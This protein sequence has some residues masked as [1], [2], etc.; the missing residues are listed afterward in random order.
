MT[1]QGQLRL[2]DHLGIGRR[3]HL[4]LNLVGAAPLARQIAADGIL[5]GLFITGGRRGGIA[6]GGLRDGCGHAVGGRRAGDGQGPVT[7]RAVA[8][9]VQL[10]KVQLD[11]LGPEA[12]HAAAQG[13]IAEI[14]GYLSQGSVHLVQEIGVGGV[15]CSAAAP[16]VDGPVRG[17]LTQG[18]SHRQG[19][20]IATGSEFGQG[21]QH[22]RVT[23][24]LIV[25]QV[26][27]G[28]IAI[29]TGRYRYDALQAGGQTGAHRFVELVHLLGAEREGVLAFR[30]A[31]GQVGQKGDGDLALGDGHQGAQPFAVG[32]GDLGAGCLVEVAGIRIAPHLQHHR[33]GCRVEGQGHRPTAAGIAAG[34]H[35][36][37]IGGQD[38][39]GRIQDNAQAGC[40]PDGRVGV[41]GV[42][43]VIIFMAAGEEQRGGQQGGQE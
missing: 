32:E 14:L 1:A 34:E 7:A 31:V 29:E 23:A 3:N 6:D 25:I 43:R 24:W 17:V 10:A 41:V 21:G 5:D 9:A 15:Q 20:C 26:T 42:G 13:C 40:H 8:A 37:A 27:A 30:L 19:G 2:D 38:T 16:A 33:T 39:H 35:R 18:L 12:V 22:R 36:L 11:P 4:E 28:G